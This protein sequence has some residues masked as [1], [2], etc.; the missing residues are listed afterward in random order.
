MGAARHN[1]SLFNGYAMRHGHQRVMDMPFADFLDFVTYWLFENLD[2]QE[3]WK[4]ESELLMPLGDMNP[5][6]VP[7]DHPIWGA[8]AE[9]AGWP[10]MGDN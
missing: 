3:S 7:A 9:M 5:D 8:E 10:M 4:L 1:W 6:T 2:E